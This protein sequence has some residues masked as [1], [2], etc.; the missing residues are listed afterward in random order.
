MEARCFG[1]DFT[2]HGPSGADSALYN[3]EECGKGLSGCVAKSL[4]AHENVDL[5]IIKKY[6]VLIP[7]VIYLHKLLTSQIESD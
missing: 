5:K 4:R 2:T 7:W 3:L 1:R 6:F